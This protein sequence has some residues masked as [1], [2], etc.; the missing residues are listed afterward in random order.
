MVEIDMRL[1]KATSNDLPFGGLH[2][3]F[4]GDFYQLPPVAQDALYKQSFSY[5]KGRKGRELWELVHYFHEL[6]ENKRHGSD[7]TTK[8]LADFLV[9]ARNGAP[10]QSKLDVMNQR[11]QLSTRSRAIV[12]ALDRGAMML[13]ATHAEVDQFNKQAFAQLVDQHQPHYRIWA[14]HVPAEKSARP[15]TEDQRRGYLRTSINNKNAFQ[16]PLL[17]YIDLAVGTRVKVIHNLA[18]QVR[19]HFLINIYLTP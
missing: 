16:A 5:D 10:V 7:V 8:P 13:A 17:P 1:R 18:T 15:L 9:G 2:I 14:A 6:K 4:T 19:P 11:L 3:L 12:A